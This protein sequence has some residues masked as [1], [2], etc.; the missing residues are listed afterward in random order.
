MKK[1]LTLTLTQ[2]CNLN[3]T[4]CYENRHSGRTMTFDTAKMIL[5]REMSP[6]TSE[7]EIEIDFFGGEPML[8]FDLIKKIVEYVRQQA[9]KH[10]FKAKYIFFASSNGTLIHGDIQ[11]WLN[12]NPSVVIGLSLDGNKAMQDLNRSNS[13]DRIDLPFF[14]KTYP[15]QLIKMTISNET[16][17]LLADGVAF[18]HEQ[19]FKVACNLAYGIDW[20]NPKYRRELISQ[21][22]KLSDYYISNPTVERATILSRKLSFVGYNT[23]VKTE[24][25]QKFCGTGTAMHTYDVD[26]KLYPCQF[27]MPISCGPEKAELAKQLIF[28]D[29][30]PIDN[31][32][33]KCRNC[34]LVK[35]CPTC[36]G[37]NY[38]S[39]G[40]IFSKDNNLCELEKIIFYANACL[41]V[42]QWEM[43]QLSELDIIEL[44]AT[45]HGC[46]RIIEE[47][48]SVVK[49]GLD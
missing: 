30:I 16:L 34:I 18:A 4:Y 27:F 15:F 48:D 9:R 3:C 8:E 1:S 28:V 39:T 10:I 11:R 36:Y 35:S 44:T 26:G 42:N 22:A 38:L 23:A 49:F 45:L 5:D 46:R 43:G 25:V 47:F 17:P 21:L 19:G 37:S 29:E 33:K 31:L 12:D 40:N 2:N 13:F 41:T 7:D 24:T 6:L 32:D 14:A 20:G